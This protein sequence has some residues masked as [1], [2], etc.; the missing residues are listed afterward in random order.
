[1]ARDIVVYMK[2]GSVKPFPHEGRPGGS[3]TKSM[4]TEIGFVVITD[5]YYNEHWIPT[6][7]IDRIETKEHGR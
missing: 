5:E 3:Y 2:D 7:D 1:M 4:R 6:N